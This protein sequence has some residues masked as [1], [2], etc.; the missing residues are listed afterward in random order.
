MDSEFSM[1]ILVTSVKTSATDGRIIGDNEVANM[2]I[3]KIIRS[4]QSCVD[5]VAW[6]TALS[7]T[8]R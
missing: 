5:F 2:A 6:I 3:H 4:A 7:Y 1:M 8:D